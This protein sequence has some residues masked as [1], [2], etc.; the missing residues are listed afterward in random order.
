LCF[1]TVNRFRYF[2]YTTSA[3]RIRKVWKTSSISVFQANSAKEIHHLVR[4]LGLKYGVDYS[5]PKNRRTLRYG[6]I[7][8]LTDQDEDGSHIK[9]LIINFLHTFWPQLLR[10]GFVQSFMTPLLKARR[11]SEVI[12]FYSMKEFN[13]WKEST[14]DAE[15][16]TVKYYKGLG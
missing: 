6:G 4:I 9:G 5:E 11:G 1:N 13:R 8:I 16:F 12:S 3:R 2:I 15:K 7:I 14:Q 10:N